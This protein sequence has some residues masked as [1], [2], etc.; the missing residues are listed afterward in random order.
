MSNG[1]TK[2]PD[3]VQVPDG[4]RG[5]F[6][7][8]PAGRPY[9]TIHVV[10]KPVAEDRAARMQAIVSELVATK[11]PDGKKTMA[12]EAPI[13]LKNLG[14]AKSPKT[15]DA[16]EKTIRAA[17]AMAAAEPHRPAPLTF[18]DIAMQFIDGRLRARFPDCGHRRLLKPLRPRTVETQKTH[19][20]RVQS[21]LGNTLVTAIT[22][23][24][25][26]EVKTKLS[27]SGLES[28]SRRGTLVF[29][30]LIL[31]FAV[32]PLE[33]LQVAP[34]AASWVPPKTAREKAFQY[35]D[36]RED[37]ILVCCKK[38]PLVYR[39][40]YA[41]LVRNGGRRDET[42]ALTWGDVTF[43]S[44]KCN[45][46]ETKTNR[47][48][49][50]VLDADVVRA[51]EAFKPIGASPDDI[52]FKGVR[53]DKI[54]AKLRLHLRLAGID[55][56]R[57]ELLKQSAAR[58]H[59]V[60]HDLRATFVTIAMAC[61]WTEFEIMRRSGHVTSTELQKY[62][63]DVAELQAMGMQ[64]FSDLD[65]LLGIEPAPGVARGVAH[66]GKFHVINGGAARSQGTG[67]GV[68]PEAQQ[69]NSRGKRGGAPTNADHGPPHGAGV[70]Q[71]AGPPDAISNLT[72][73]IAAATTAGK[74][75]LVERLTTQLE[76][77][78]A[79]GQ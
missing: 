62:K 42:L 8:G 60:L 27:A 20:N 77:L 78:K 38:I 25:C 31:S 65:T 53:R 21:V 71:S 63:R 40:F 43:A 67:H 51:L 14:E 46:D 68:F 12:A 37:E 6:R 56:L 18:R 32:D 58:R 74:W 69:P 9:Q 75:A 17:M 5:R 24:Q 55:K 23:K 11:L 3:L 39:L 45:L 28:S 36:P 61:G 10:S 29:V 34:I 33:I 26:D 7:C 66:R 49:W 16:V 4:W 73:A 72:A 41:F 57:P 50:W 59:L 30:R 44:G 13:A 47:P 1:A 54:A 48:R 35:L 79:A 2:A 70:A 22:K 15:F 64:W 19:L 52:V 76:G